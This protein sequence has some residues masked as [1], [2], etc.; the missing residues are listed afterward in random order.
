MI[1]YV[2]LFAGI[3]GFRQAMEN[4]SQTHNIK[5]KCVGY[6]EID[7]YALQTYKANFDTSKELEI[8]DITKIV[9]YDALPNF[10]ALFAGFPCQP[11]SIMG[12]E[13][14]FLDSRGTLFFQIEKI[15][16]AKKPMFFILENVRGLTTHN[17][18]ETFKSIKKI[19]EQKLGYTVSSWVLNSRDYGVPQ[20]RRRVYIV[21]TKNGKIIDM[22]LEKDPSKIPYPSTW[23]LLEKEVDE[24]YFLSDKLLKTILA[25]G[26]GN[27]YSKSEINP[28]IA[29]PLTASMHKM[30]RAN[31]DNYFSNSF[32]NGKYDAK[33][34]AVKLK[35]GK[36]KI[37]K[38]T[39]L[40]A[41]RLQ[42]FKDNFVENAIKTGVSNTQLYRQAG[43]SISV[44]VAQSVLEQVLN[45]NVIN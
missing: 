13:L 2:D 8:G 32:I 29:K 19:L 14:G 20:T 40:E 38:L 27:Y 28:I 3:G 1:K 5:S 6:S 35:A 17:N 44:P 43:N 30:H 34:K 16:E 9:D 26:S 41:F 42:G 25:H 21:G 24:K 18:G 39:P 4:L 36:K 11:F 23:H 15:I 37:R 45:S 31:Q 33:S 10:D 7:K 22:P 12:K